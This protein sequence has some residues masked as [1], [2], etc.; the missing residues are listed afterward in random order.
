MKD[1]DCDVCNDDELVKHIATLKS[2]VIEGSRIHIEASAKFDTSKVEAYV[3]LAF[4]CTKCK[5]EYE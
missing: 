2:D 1:R 3:K 4:Y 5:R